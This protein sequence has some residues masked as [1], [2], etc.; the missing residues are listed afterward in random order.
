[1]RQIDGI[2]LP[3]LEGQPDGL[4]FFDEADLHT[5]YLRHVFAFHGLNQYG[6]VR[7]C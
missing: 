5:P 6:I 7:V 4:G 3:T 1:M 2:E